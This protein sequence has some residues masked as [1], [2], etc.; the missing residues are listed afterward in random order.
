[1]AQHLHKGG[2][3]GL[4]AV[5]W[6]CGVCD[7]GVCNGGGWWA[8]G[9]LKGQIAAQLPSVMAWQVVVRGGR[10]L[11]AVWRQGAAVCAERLQGWLMVD[12]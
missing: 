1:M 2:L 9:G 4:G 7:E 8:T 3:G 10:V 6:A 5:V 12:G 11:G